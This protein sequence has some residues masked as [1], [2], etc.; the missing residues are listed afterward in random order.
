ML[1]ELN[2]AEWVVLAFAGLG[3]SSV[4]GFIIQMVLG[5]HDIP[6]EGA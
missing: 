3:F 4:I 1:G 5:P 2:I 6:D